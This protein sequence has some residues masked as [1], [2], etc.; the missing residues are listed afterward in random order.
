VTD[1]EA[2]G[3]WLKARRRSLDLTQ[4][5]IAQRA[6]CAA[7]TVRKLE[8]GRRRPSKPVAQQLADALQLAGP[9]RAEFLRLARSQPVAAPGQVNPPTAVTQAQGQ[10]APQPGTTEPVPLL[11][12]K[13]FLPRPR[14]QRVTRLRL[15]ARLEAGLRGSLIL[16]AAPAG[17]GKTT[18]LAEWLNQPATA[19]RPVAWLALDA[20]DSDPIQF[21][22]YFI[23]ASQRLAPS[24]GATILPLLQTPQPPPLE[25]LL[26]VLVNDLAQAPDGSL[27]VLDDYHVIDA[28]AVHQIVTFLLDHLPPQLHLVMASRVDPPLPLARLRVRGQLTEV[29][30]ADLRFT[31]AEAAT[32]LQE[33]MGLQ[34]ATTDVA[35]IE[36]RTEGWIAG[37]QLAAI[38][39]QDLPAAEVSA[40]I[41][42]FTGSHR[43][44]VDYLVDEVLASQPAHIQSFL[45][46]SSILD[47]LS[48]PLCDAV[49]GEETSSSQ[50]QLEQ[51]ERANL[52]LV[53]LDEGRRWYRYHHLFAQVL[54]E[55]LLASTDPAQVATLHGRAAAWFEQ[56]GLIIEAVKH[57]LAA[58][59][60]AGAARLIEPQ[61]RLLIVQGQVHVVAQWLN[62]LPKAFVQVRP[63]LLDLQAVVY[64]CA[65]DLEAAERTIQAAEAAFVLNGHAEE[66][67]TM[68][69][70]TSLL[71]AN[72]A[73]ARGDL[74][75]CTQLSQQAL[76]NLPPNE[77]VRRVTAQLGISQ[78][79]LVTGD[80]GPI[81]QRLVTDAV[82]FARSSGNL[83]TLYN[84]TINLAELQRRQ[85]RLHQAA[86]TYRAANEV[87]PHLLGLQ[88]LPNGA[89]YYCGLG[90][91]L[92]EW[93]DLEAAEAALLQ[94]QEMIRRGR[95]THGD[96]VTFGYIALARLQQCRGEPAV[97]L[98]TLN[99]LQA[100]ASER[101]FAAH[102]HACALAAKAHLALQQGDTRAAERWADA[103]KLPWPG[104]LDYLYERVYL[105]LAR[106][107]IAQGRTNVAGSFLNEALGL[108][109]RLLADAET[110]MRQD[111]VIQIRIL[112][113]LARQAQGDRAT[114]EDLTRALQLAAPAGYVRVFVDEGAPMAALL[115]Q[116]VERNRWPPDIRSYAEQILAALQIEGVDDS[117]EPAPATAATRTPLPMGEWL[118]EREVEVLRLLAAGGSNQTIARVLVVEVGTVKRHVSNILGKLQVQSR[119]EAV[120]RARELHLL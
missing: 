111:S 32:F 42:S 7:E 65:N 89:S 75:P 84:S 10:R 87:A 34:L 24:I 45:L 58:Q 1:H 106:V 54:H 101:H 85:G 83:L 69:G 17:F 59:D 28:P 6:G 74:A 8:A 107:R 73:R 33:V 5:E 9:E 113:A 81:N 57:H 2:F 115:R 72:I 92:Y 95:Q 36:A 30:A 52:F 114:A 71:R 14:A 70:Y 37:L 40:F 108:L 13:L 26:P 18:L 77:V 96:F 23:T 105:A 41:D 31:T 49:V 27:L 15:L 48:G 79:F 116:G 120:A 47:R 91:M 29:R 61:G 35:A 104:E 60:W 20:V 78:V 102:L 38:S 44:V 90:A 110:A 25:P 66:A 93:N 3:H 67:R 76:A 19:S 119:L 94:G 100:L 56:Q 53:P 39:L 103:N 46:H 11:A 86:A 64:F 82:A 4:E 50:R 112:R 97:A 88:T 62:A 55:R 16:I 80:V 118:T 117:P 99:E 98:A 43:F 21:L 109:D 68:L 63:Y 22:R 12:T 51:L